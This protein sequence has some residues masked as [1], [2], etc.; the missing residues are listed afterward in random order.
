M[1]SYIVLIVIIFLWVLSGCAQ[2]VDIDAEKEE[3]NKVLDQE[4]QVW[5]TED[6]DL[7]SGIFAHD[8]DMV[9]FGTEAGERIVGWQALEDAMHKQ[10]EATDSSKLSAS[11]RS[12]KINPTGNTAWFSE[13]ISWQ[14]VSGG[15]K[16]N[17][18]GLRGTGVLEKRNGKWVIVQLHYSLPSD[19]KPD[20]LSEPMM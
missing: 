1:K 13:L 11:D 17:L 19:G 4:I 20:S 10:F 2:R 14:L 6:M 18:K 15:E 7:L 3:V 5:E 9:T 12:V 16:M 8:S